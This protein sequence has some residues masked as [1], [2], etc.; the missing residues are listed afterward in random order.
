MMSPCKDCA[1]RSISCHAKCR[2]YKLYQ[3]Y[4]AHR[5]EVRSRQNQIEADY[6][7]VIRRKYR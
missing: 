5:R 4:C 3:A 7:A 2:D 1:E 6:N